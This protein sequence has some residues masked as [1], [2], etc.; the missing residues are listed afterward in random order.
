MQKPR[1]GGLYR[2]EYDSRQ[3]RQPQIEHIK[4]RASPD[5]LLELVHLYIDLLLEQLPIF[6]VILTLERG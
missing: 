5:E 6:R 2:R 3:E 4:T 1:Q